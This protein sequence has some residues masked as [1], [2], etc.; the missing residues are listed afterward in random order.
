VEYKAGMVILVECDRNVSGRGYGEQ[1]SPSFLYGDFSIKIVSSR[2]RV[3]CLQ[4][5]LG[6][7]DVMCRDQDHF[8]LTSFVK[9]CFVRDVSEQTLWH[10]LG[11]HEA[12][13]AV[14]DGTKKRSEALA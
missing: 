7:Q 12:V 5:Q 4:M 14:D 13:C 2:I 9:F 11:S 10:R 1:S 3:L 8:I 6:N